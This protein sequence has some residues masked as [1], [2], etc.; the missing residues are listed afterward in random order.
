RPNYRSLLSAAAFFFGLTMVI[1]SG[2]E[3]W[4]LI[5]D[6]V[7]YQVRLKTF[8]I[9]LTI[10][11]ALQVMSSF[12]ELPKKMTRIGTI[13]LTAISLVSL[14]LPSMDHVQTAREAA[15]ILSVPFSLFSLLYAIRYYNRSGSDTRVFFW[16][17]GILLFGGTLDLLTV[18]K[19]WNIPP[20]MPIASALFAVIATVLLF[21]RSSDLANRYRTL[22][23]H[24][25]DAILILNDQFVILELN[26]QAECFGLHRDRAFKAVVVSSSA[27]LESHLKSRLPVVELHLDDPNLLFESI[28]IQL[29]NNLSMV[30][31]RNITERKRAENQLLTKTRFETANLIASSVAHDFSNLMMAVEGQLSIL[32]K[33]IEQSQHGR[34]SE[35][36]N[37][38]SQGN[39]FIRRIQ[40][41]VQSDFSVA[42]AINPNQIIEGLL[43]ISRQPFLSHIQIHFQPQG[44]SHTVRFNSEAF[45]Q[46]IFN[47]IL[48]AKDAL[49]DQ[50]NPQVW[51]DDNS[52]NEWF[53]LHIEDSGP[54]IPEDLMNQIFEPFVTSKAA[55]EGSGLGLT[56]AKR[57]VVEYGGDLAITKSKYGQGAA[58]LLSLPLI[59]GQIMASSTFNSDASILILEDEPLIL[60]VL[61]EIL[62]EAGYKVFPCQTIEDAEGCFAEHEIELLI[63]D[64]IL[65]SESVE[66]GFEYA[67][68]AVEEEKVSN[69]LMMSG[70]IPDNITGLPDTWSFLQKPFQRKILLERIE[71]ILCRVSSNLN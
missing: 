66:D 52:Q 5:S 1:L 33:H 16:I 55:H 31:L 64:V 51:I 23:D 36:E 30:V 17:C 40:N 34:F 39:L 13:I 25:T 67:N 18:F 15:Y 12:S 19:V 58:F 57:L 26:D 42:S 3:L 60:E 29:E 8:S 48:N 10:A 6:S 27:T 62:Q 7:Y 22:V 68:R 32:G 28:A 59:D 37:L 2:I 45:E 49:V 54:G 21:I 63:S 70:Y 43:S 46:V 71:T 9:Y 20:S 65:K 47:L 69:V 44:V 35:V 53:V 41:I 56:V 61:E 14:V 50:I 38:L 4:Y 11:M 24:S